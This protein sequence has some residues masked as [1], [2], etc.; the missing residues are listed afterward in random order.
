MIIQTVN[1][2]QFIDNLLTDDYASWRYEDAE[3]LFDYYENLSIDQGEPIELDRVAIRCDWSV[4]D[5]IEQ[6]M[7]EYDYINGMEDLVDNSYEV[8]EH[9]DGSLLYLA[10]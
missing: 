3:A 6:V 2:N 9:D 8:I 5:N 7:D 10:F 4:A 1:K